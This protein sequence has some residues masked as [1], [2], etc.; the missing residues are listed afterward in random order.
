MNSEKWF[1]PGQT[2]AKKTLREEREEKLLRLAALAEEPITAYRLEKDG[3]IPHVTASMIISSLLRNGQ[4]KAVASE[5]FRTGKKLHLLDITNGGLFRLLSS[6]AGQDN[7]TDAERLILRHRKKH[8]VFEEYLHMK[9]LG[10]EKL[11]RLLSLPLADWDREY[12]AEQLLDNLYPELLPERPDMFTVE[13]E[14]GTERSE[15]VVSEGEMG[16]HTT[17]VNPEMERHLDELREFI[18]QYVKRNP[19]VVDEMLQLVEEWKTAA[20]NTLER[21]EQIET[22]LT[23]DFA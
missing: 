7:W 10:L 14:N 21:T 8:W 20:R 12:F 3:D 16:W 23:N 22:R 19:G 11:G 5:T 2:K 18:K 15:M 1:S 4:I 6:Y 17:T 9:E 13:E